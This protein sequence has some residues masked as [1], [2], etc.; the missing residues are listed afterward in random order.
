M[1]LLLGSRAKVVF[2]KQWC[3]FLTKFYGLYG[4]VTIYSDF[5]VKVC[6]VLSVC[7]C[8]LGGRCHVKVNR[9]SKGI[10]AYVMYITFTVTV[11][12]KQFIGNEIV[13]YCLQYT[14]DPIY[15][16]ALGPRSDIAI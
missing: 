15:R 6:M 1:T 8:W 5:S 4:K 2:A 3:Y 16:D 12:H 7:V 11:C 9:V 10:W 13:V 14:V